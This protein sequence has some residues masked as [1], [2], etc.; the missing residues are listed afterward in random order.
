MDL[1]QY[2]PSFYLESKEIVN[3]QDALSMEDTELKND[4]EDLKK[5]FF[6]ST[7]TW[8]IELWEKYVGI[9]SDK[10][11]PLQS[12]R[13]AVIA[14]LTGQGTCTKELLTTICENFTKGEIEIIEHIKDYSFTIKFLTK[15]GIPTNISTLNKI[16]ERMKPAHLGYE[17]QF[18]YNTHDFVARYTHEQLKTKTH[19]RIRDF[20]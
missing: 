6:V 9:A 13:D 3:L 15:K 18:L 4:I 2:L 12:R 1:K 11:K 10:T 8:A 17:Y 16:I 20:Y 19:E 7:C 14:A 5:Q